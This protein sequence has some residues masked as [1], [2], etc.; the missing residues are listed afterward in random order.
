MRTRPV[1][2]KEV[3]PEAFHPVRQAWR[4]EE[5]RMHLAGLSPVSLQMLSQRLTFH[6]FPQFELRPSEGGETFDQPG[7]KFPKSLH[8]TSTCDLIQRSP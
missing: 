1:Q 7:M 5:H 8:A 6:V 4:V 2:R 3:T